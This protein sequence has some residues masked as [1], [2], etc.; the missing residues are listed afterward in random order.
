MSLQR[1]QTASTPASITHAAVR[2]GSVNWLFFSNTIVNYVG[3]GVV[4]ILTFATA[5]YVVRHLGPE[6]FGIVALVQVIAGFA[7]L[8]NLGVGRALT[9]YVAEL[10]WKGEFQKINQL[11]QTAWATCLVAG[12]VGL[13]ILIVPGDAIAKVFFR[14]GPEVDAVSCFAIYI[15]GVAL[16][17]TMLLEAVSALPVA[18]QRFGITNAINV[19]SGA[20]RCLGPVVVLACGFSIRAVLV[21]ILVSNLLAIAAFS[22][23]SRTFIPG[24]SFW[25]RF[26]SDAFRKLFGFSLPL[27]L[28]A[29]FSLI[30]ARID[31]FILAYYLPLAAITFY[32]LPSM[33]SDKASASVANV[34]SV[35]FP[36]TSELHSMGA[37]DKVHELYLRSTKVLTLI[38]LPF[39]VALLTLPGPI[40]QLWL[41]T[42]Y[43]EQGAVVLRVLGAATFLSAISGVATVTCLGIGRAWVPAAFAFASS[44]VTLIANLVLIPAYGINGAAFAAFLP[45]ILVVPLFV[46]TVTHMLR[47]SQWE[48]FCQ[49]FLRPFLAASAQFAILFHFQRYADDFG[50]LVSLFTISVLVYATISFFWAMTKQERSA[51]SRVFRRQR[52]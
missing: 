31:R 12:F 14:G 10:Y 33:I 4:L 50:A 5:P 40:L 37:H 1:L 24:L 9:K 28:A 38:T 22:F 35:V 3:Q 25:P 36:F 8:L 13:A 32:T 47:F 46:W 42:E 26:S 23:A 6:L 17:A 16:L 29:I 2:E 11:F 44:G 18:L 43:A 45:Q 49:A 21:A 27:F 39:T 52:G 20:V 34:T 41:G 51:L 48:L 7:G 19:T 15:A 30:V